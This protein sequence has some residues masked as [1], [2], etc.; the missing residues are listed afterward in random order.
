[1]EVLPGGVHVWEPVLDAGETW[2][3]RLDARGGK[4]PRISRVEW[5]SADKQHLDVRV[6][7]LGEEGRVDLVN[8]PRDWG[9]L[10]AA[11]PGTSLPWVLDP[12][13]TPRVRERKVRFD[14]RDVRT[15]EL[16]VRVLSPRVAGG[17]GDPAR[18]AV[19]VRVWTLWKAPA[20]R[21]TWMQSGH[22]PG[23]Y[24][25]A[26]LPPGRYT[27]EVGNPACGWVE[28]GPVDLSADESLDLGTIDLP[29]PA[30]VRRAKDASG[31]RWL[32]RRDAVETLVAVLEGPGTTSMGC[33]A[34]SYLLVDPADRSSGIAFE[35]AAGESVVV[36][37]DGVIEGPPGR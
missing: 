35:L 3:G 13:E 12:K 15:G 1:V 32:L 21:G 4:L 17:E 31:T 16:R 11:T 9:A 30:L 19:E 7:A 34:G 5:V 28:L 33:P 14:A 36:T 8:L 24:S 23:E 29:A 10:L 6:A 20:D 18:S 22:R 26:G 2:T 27:V 37:D 25:L